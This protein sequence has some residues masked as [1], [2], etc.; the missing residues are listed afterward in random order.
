MTTFSPMEMRA[1]GGWG[2]EIKKKLMW[3]GTNIGST[4]YSM[5]PVFCGMYG[6]IKW[7]EG[8][9]ANE[10]LHHRD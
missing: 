4:W 1:F 10:L 9:Y 2:Y 6:L 3:H 7:A 8:K 5:I